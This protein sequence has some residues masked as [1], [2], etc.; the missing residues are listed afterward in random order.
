MTKEI[1]SKELSLDELEKAQQ[2]ILEQIKIRQ[3]AK[4]KQ[5]LDSIMQLIQDNKLDPREIAD[6]LNAKS[7]RR[8]APALYRNPTNARQTWSGHGTPPVWF[9]EAPDK[10]K[11]KIKQPKR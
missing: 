10:E 8:K 6:L 5:A 1:P 2:D 4:R 3:A 11:L 7:R 9:S